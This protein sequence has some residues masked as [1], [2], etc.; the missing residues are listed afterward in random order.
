MKYFILALS[1]F[2]C[3]SLHSQVGSLQ[4]KVTDPYLAEGLPFATVS[5]MVDGSMVGT[6][7][8]FDGFYAISNVPEGIYL[9]TI[10]YIGYTEFQEEI[11]ITDDQITFLD[12]E[13]KEDV[14]DMCCGCGCHYAAYT[15][16]LYEQD[17]MTT[18]YTYGRWDIRP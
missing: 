10:Q 18:G 13:L 9:V 16:P 2:T 7:T 11:T 14:I 4:G 5:L 1:I 17:E 3:F 6:S 8:D 15:I 12:I